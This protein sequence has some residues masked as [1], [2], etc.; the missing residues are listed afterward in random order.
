[1][2]ETLGGC[3]SAV[4]EVL[5]GVFG[6]ALVEADVERLPAEQRAK[7]E[8]EAR[9]EAER[10]AKLEVE[11]RLAAERQAKQALLEELAH[12]HARLG[13]PPEHQS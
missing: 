9:A 7:L 12:L 4:R 3:E 13:S 5:G 2:L 1:M 10:K 8:A 6:E 11:A